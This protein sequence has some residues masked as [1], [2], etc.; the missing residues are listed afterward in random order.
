MLG[1]TGLVA[2]FRSYGEVTLG[3]SYAYDLMVYPDLDFGIVADSVPTSL[4]AEL[5]GAICA[6]DGVHRVAFADLIHF[7]PGHRVKGYWLGIEFP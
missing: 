1:A 7:E 2:V 3:G 4:A 6:L 5:L